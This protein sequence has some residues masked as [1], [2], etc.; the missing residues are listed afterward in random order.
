M[1]GVSRGMFLGQHGIGAI[2]DTVCL[3]KI[4]K[5]AFKYWYLL[6]LGNASRS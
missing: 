6:N 2:I 5:N 1:N 3:R 4:A